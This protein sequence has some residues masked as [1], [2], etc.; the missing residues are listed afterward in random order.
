MSGRQFVLSEKLVAAIHESLGGYHGGYR[1]VHARGR[2]YRG[3]FTA[4]PAARAISRASHLQGAPTRATVRFSFGSGDPGAPPGKILGMAT[5]F[6]LAS[7]TTTDIVCLNLPQFPARS[8]EEVIA[9]LAALRPVAD[10]LPDRA[11][12]GAFLAS[13]PAAAAVFQTVMTMPTPADFMQTFSAFHAFRF[14][15]AAN[16]TRSA[17]YHWEPATPT[18]DGAREAGVAN[19]PDALFFA[20]ETRL[21]AAPASFDLVLEFAGEGD[22][23]E[24]PS[25]PWPS[26]RPRTT[27]GRLD[28]LAPTSVEEIGD[29]IMVHDPTRVV[30]GIECPDD[31]ILHARR[32]AYEISVAERMGAAKTP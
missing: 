1:A 22:P 15:D 17:R 29:P 5:K 30:D 12:I 28:I 9:L 25:A 27:I 19:D 10:G 20:L 2:I 24:D 4:S 14:V 7:G 13:R 6:Y 21:L 11:K 23:L 18:T 8:P 3:T 32:G 31:P 26:D 16:Q